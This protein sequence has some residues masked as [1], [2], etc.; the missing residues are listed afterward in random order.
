MAAS[1]CKVEGCGPLV[2]PCCQADVSEGDLEEAGRGTQVRL[3]GG[4]H[5][6]GEGGCQEQDMEL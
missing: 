3:G 2:V 4:G 1:S 6:W 5:F